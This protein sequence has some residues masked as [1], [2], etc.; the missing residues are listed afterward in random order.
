MRIH[1]V[2]RSRVWDERHARQQID[3]A[4]G[5]SR[6]QFPCGIRTP[7]R[8]DH[9]GER[10]RPY[11]LVRPVHREALELAAYRLQGGTVGRDKHVGQ[12]SCGL[13]APRATVDTL[14][15]RERTGVRRNQAV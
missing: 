14:D 3:A 7:V 11:L 15:G 12:V 13:T 9:R 4:G 10:A 1:R 6:G 2:A 5:R 8:L